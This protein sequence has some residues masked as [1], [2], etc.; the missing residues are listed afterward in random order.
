MSRL[1]SQLRYWAW[2]LGLILLLILISLRW[3]DPPTS[4]II[5]QQ[6]FSNSHQQTS[7]NFTWVPLENIS[8]HMLVAVI[9]GEDQRF[10]HHYGLD[11]TEVIKILRFESGKPRGASTL[12]Q[13]VAKNL[14]LWQ[15][16]SYPRKI[17]EAILAISIDFL[18]GKPRVLEMYLNIVQFGPNTYGV[19][20]AARHFFNKSAAQ[21]NRYEA[22]RLVAVLPNPDKRIAN[23]PNTQVRNRQNWILQQMKNL[24]GVEIITELTK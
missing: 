15:A 9:A 6:N 17:L 18:W 21:L 10:L 4:S 3:L 19:E 2:R 1:L 11:F 23:N 5:W 12:T 20:N 13:Q 16:R 22:A 14:F 7:V 8:N 24:D